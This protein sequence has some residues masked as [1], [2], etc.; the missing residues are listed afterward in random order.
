[1]IPAGLALALIGITAIGSIIFGA[2]FAA[3]VLE[4]RI[5]KE[6]KERLMKEFVEKYNDRVDQY[7]E[8]VNK[9]NKETK[10]EEEEK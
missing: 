2:T 9:V 3:D 1:M 10:E 8:A 7:L 5:D 6:L 4:S